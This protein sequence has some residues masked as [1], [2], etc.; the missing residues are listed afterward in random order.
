M[1]VRV[2]VEVEVSDAGEF[3][4]LTIGDGQPITLPADRPAPRRL[5]RE[6]VAGVRLHSSRRRA[7]PES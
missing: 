6:L 4:S 7:C 3:L 5:T 2:T 1:K